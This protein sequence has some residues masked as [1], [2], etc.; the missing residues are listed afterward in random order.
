MSELNK[1]FDKLI[2]SLEER[3]RELNCIYEI[4]EILSN[5]EWNTAEA[6]IEVI[7]VIP[8]GWQYPDI[9]R[10][11][12]FYK[13][14]EYQSEG[15]RESPWSL[16][17]EI[18]INGRKEGFIQ[19][20]YT[21]E[22]PRID[23]GPFLNDEI[24]LLRTICSRLSLYLTYQKLKIVFNKW[25]NT[26]QDF[27]DRKEGEWKVVLDLLKRTDPDLYIRISRKMLNNLVWQGFSEA[28][29]LLQEFG[30]TH[31]Y[32]QSEVLGEVNN[33]LQKRKFEQSKG[34]TTEI[35]KLAQ[36]Y[37]SK[38]EILSNIQKW[39]QQDKTAF[40]VRAAANND[41]SLTDIVEAIRRY[42]QIAPE[43]LEL[44]PSA[45]IGVRA[46]LLRRFF[47][48][49]L[50]F[51]TIAKNYV[52]VHDFNE[53]ISKIIFPTGSHGKL[54]GKSAGIFLAERVL[55]KN[56]HDQEIL[57]SIKVPKTWYISSDTMI[58]FMNFNNLEEILEQKYK[59]LSEVRKEYPHVVQLFKNSYFPPDIIK[60]LS[61]AL[62]DF[63][64]RP[65]IVRSSSLLEDRLGTA[66][67]GKYKSLFITNQGTKQ[68]RLDALMDAIAEVYAST[69]GPDPMEYRTEHNLI[70]FHEEMA[71]MIQEVVGQQVGP[72]FLPC[73]AGVAFST[74]EF[75]WSP[76]IKRE[77]GLIR[78]VPGL[79]TRAVDRV[80]ADYPILIAPGQPGLRANVSTEDIIRYSPQ[81]IDV[82]NMQS[83]EFE[84]IEL[85][86]LFRKYGNDYPKFENVV[87][88]Y[89]HHALKRPN[90]FNIN[91]EKDDIIVTFEG[92]INNT[93]FVTLFKRILHEL[94][95]A[96]NTPVDV[97]FA[98]DGTDLFI[99]QCRPQSFSK[100]D[101]PTPIPPN[102]PEEQTLFTA[103]RYISNGTVP[104]ITHIV[105]VNPEKYSEIK[106]LEKF[107]TVSDAISRLNEKLPKRQFILM[108]PGRWGSRGDIK[109]GVSVTYSDINNTAVLI[110]IARKKGNYVPDLSFGT[111]FFQDLVEASIRYLP[112]YPDEKSVI[113]NEDFL[114]KS[115]NCISTY[116]PDNNDLTEIIHVID[117]PEVF[118]GKI[119]KIL[120]N[121][122]MEKA[123]A[124]FKDP[125]K[126]PSKT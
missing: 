4:E 38:T 30:P 48:E 84:T 72:Y 82:L 93:R 15:F 95:T 67:S 88:V 117:V 45:R 90:A 2:V 100:Y 46:S 116:V 34:I 6:L 24:N 52:R 28:E 39:M 29:H 80:S 91:F 10:I 78:I 66:F 89:E 14:K 110:E 107:K 77:D 23:K 1:P 68:E 27:T 61:V 12:I 79:G 112:L 113:F 73:F 13:E 16:Q 122:D 56:I 103:N 114:I 8:I 76:R 37:M 17:E 71:V 64:D 86:E 74:N 21:E 7:K 32:Q 47:S 109:L 18:I 108:G 124:Y 118:Q 125:E 35:F 123:V 102:I 87:S 60:S 11:R 75:R 33:P 104:D 120:M 36:R 81:L 57:N 101:S 62:D 25:Q 44:M 53:L 50:D 99:L 20:Y 22:K 51:I 31:Q 59:S 9:C 58:H 106:S 92:L 98:S 65:L 119:L 55:K 85:K 54:G 70:D 43:G 63:G 40:L 97:E 96:L 121:A 3:V 126:K 105:Y 69:F 41:S 49:Q 19:I 5:P 42:Y 26:K 94:S 83:H 111:H 115:P